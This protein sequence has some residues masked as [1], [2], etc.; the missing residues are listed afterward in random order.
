MT[1]PLPFCDEHPDGS[2]IPCGPCG[3]ARRRQ[4]RWMARQQLLT[5][6]AGFIARYAERH[7]RRFA[8]RGILSAGYA[9]QLEASG[10]VVGGMR[11]GA[12]VPVN[13]TTERALTG[14]LPT[15]DRAS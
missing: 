11:G 13:G 6:E 3:A 9:A 1:A 2:F 7:P 4:D 14:E 12:V 15:G 8:K 5:A 10:I